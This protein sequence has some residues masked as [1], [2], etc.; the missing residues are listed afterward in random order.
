[1]VSSQRQISELAQA[2]EKKRRHIYDAAWRPQVNDIARNLEFEFGLTTVGYTTFEWKVP[3]G[4]GEFSAIASLHYV[5]DVEGMQIPCV[6]RCHLSSELARS[7]MPMRAQI[8]VGRSQTRP[9]IEFDNSLFREESPNDTSFSAH[10]EEFA[11]RLGQQLTE[12]SL[13]PKLEQDLEHLAPSA[14]D[15]PSLGDMGE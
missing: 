6:C 14:L 5:V 13:S 15:E 7:G 2:F 8:L 3:E 11:F 4:V 12:C 9:P 1:M 10:R